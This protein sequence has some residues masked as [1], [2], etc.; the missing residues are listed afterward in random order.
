MLAVELGEDKQVAALAD[1]E[2]R[3]LARKTVRAKAYQLGE[4]LG[5]AAGEGRRAGFAGH[6]GVRAAGTGGRR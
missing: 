6:G 5:W 4:P 3:A 1:H 2:G